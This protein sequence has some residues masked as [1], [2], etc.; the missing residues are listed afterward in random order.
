M[1]VI[2]YFTVYINL[3]QPGKAPEMSEKENGESK[4]GELVDPN[5]FSEYA[6]TD[7]IY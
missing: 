7:L 1:E 5:S 4:P 6:E 3:N 2:E